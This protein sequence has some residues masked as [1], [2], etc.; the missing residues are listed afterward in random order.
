MVAALP[1]LLAVASAIRNG[2]GVDAE[3]LAGLDQQRRQR[4]TDHIVDEKRGEDA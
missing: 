1:M 3:Q 4:D 2:I